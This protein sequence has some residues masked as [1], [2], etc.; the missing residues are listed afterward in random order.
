M[1]NHPCYVTSVPRPLSVR[2]REVLTYA[3]AGATD[4]VIGKILF[5]TV[6][7]VR[8]HIENSMRKLNAKNKT[9]AVAQAIRNG[10]IT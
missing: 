7:S 10:E 6:P 3:A 4:A 1:P 8:A 2:E 5:I 9:Q